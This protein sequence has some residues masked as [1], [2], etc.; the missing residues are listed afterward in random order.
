MQQRVEAL[1]HLQNRMPELLEKL[2]GEVEI[3]AEMDLP[4][5]GCIY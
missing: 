4:A 5:A 3:P 2:E 1:S